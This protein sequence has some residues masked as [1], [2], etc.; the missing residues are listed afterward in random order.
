M[1]GDVSHQ[2]D[3]ALRKQAVSQLTQSVGYAAAAL[4]L[5]P[6]PG[7]EILGVMPLHVGMLIGI[8][9]LHGHAIS[10]DG[11]VELVSRIGLAAGVSIVGSRLATTAAKLLL[12]GFGG[13]LSAPVMYASTLAI[14]AVADA[15][16]ERGGHL[17]PA[18]MREVYRRAHTEA[19]RA[20]DP[21]QARSD[22]ARDLA[23]AAAA[24]ESGSTTEADPAAESPAERLATLKT[25]LEQ[26][27]IEPEEH[28]TAKARILREL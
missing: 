1:L 7:T 14:G 23:E 11:A 2:P 13:L 6:I 9:E 19:R 16:F 5:L 28:D 10:R 3:P 21:D 27:L 25:L 18:D 24:K 20:Y 17:G 22:A 15:Y 8:S 26:G 12:P 4:T